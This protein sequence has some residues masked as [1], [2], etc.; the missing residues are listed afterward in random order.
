MYFHSIQENFPR[1]NH[2]VFNQVY[3]VDKFDGTNAFEKKRVKEEFIQRSARSQDRSN[4]YSG[5]YFQSYIAKFTS[6]ALHKLRNISFKRLKIH[7]VKT[8]RITWGTQF[9][10]GPNIYF[11]IHYWR[12]AHYEISSTFGTSEGIT[13]DFRF[14]PPPVGFLKWKLV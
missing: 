8:N 1:S 13:N 7:A 6:R 5:K 9:A 10:T 2:I 11:A 3:Y 12:V 14:F 4:L